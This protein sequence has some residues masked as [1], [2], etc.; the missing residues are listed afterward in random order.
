M[1]FEPVS[2][3]TS[4]NPLCVTKD[5]GKLLETVLSCLGITVAKSVLISTAPFSPKKL[6]QIM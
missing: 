4:L 5:G 6:T 3:S 2:M 1:Y